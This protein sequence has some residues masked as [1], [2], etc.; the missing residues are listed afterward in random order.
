MTS[1]IRG[2]FGNGGDSFVNGYGIPRRDVSPKEETPIEQVVTPEDK[3]VAPDDVMAYLN[4][5]SMVVSPKQ[6]VA[7]VE[8]DEK[9]AARAIDATKNF[10]TIAAIVEQEV[11]KELAPIVLEALLNKLDLQM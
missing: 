4:N 11:G 3:S 7:P 9:V 10:E 8:L 1:G 5:S 2:I 6:S